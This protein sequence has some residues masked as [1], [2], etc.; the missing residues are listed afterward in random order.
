MSSDLPC[1]P[2]CGC[3]KHRG[4][5][6]PTPEERRARNA[7]RMRQRRIAF[8]DENREIERRWRERHPEEARARNRGAKGLQY[9][10]KYKYGMTPEQYTQMLAAQGGCCYLCSEPLDL[11]KPRKIHVDHDHS[12]CR[13]VRSCGKCIRGIACEPCNKG[14]GA[15]GDAPERMRRAADRLEAAQA[16]VAARLAEKPVQAELFDLNEAARRR[17]ESA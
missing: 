4:G 16:E 3:Y 10:L 12:C 2:G 17:E 15:F 11:D 13:G 7:E 8:P 6:M 14:I 9:S 5:V 1:Q